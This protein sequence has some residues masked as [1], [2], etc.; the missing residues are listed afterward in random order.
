[1]QCEGGHPLVLY[2]VH[3]MEVTVCL[4]TLP[5]DNKN[6]SNG[7]QISTAAPDS[8]LPPIIFLLL[9]SSYPQHSLG[10]L[11]GVAH[12]RQQQQVQQQRQGA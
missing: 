10:A 5:T 12:F 3:D 7:L 4:W 2:L 11:G 8:L 1:M 9:H 6:H